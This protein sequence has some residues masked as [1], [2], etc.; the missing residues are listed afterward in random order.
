MWPSRPLRETD[1][2]VTFEGFR[3][4]AHETTVRELFVGLERVIPTWIHEVRLFQS[5]T[6]EVGTAA[7]VSVDRSYRR[8]AIFIYDPFYAIPRQ[9]QRRVLIHEVSHIYTRPLVEFVEEN[10]L[11]HAPDGARDALES[12]I[13]QIEESC[14]QDIVWALETLDV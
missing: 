10:L 12:L 14:T 9:E 11:T 1:M 3:S 6:N 4:A 8:V 13:E 7:S 2:R 5:S